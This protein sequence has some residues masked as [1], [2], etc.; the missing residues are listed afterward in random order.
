[1]HRETLQRLGTL[2]RS[3]WV[4]TLSVGTRKTLWYR[5]PR[6]LRYFLFAGWVVGWISDSVIRHGFAKWFRGVVEYAVAFP[7]CCGVF[8]ASCR[9]PVTKIITSLPLCFPGFQRAREPEKICGTENPES[10]ATF[11]LQD[12]LCQTSCR[13]R[14]TKIITSLPLRFSDFQRAREPE[15]LCGTENPES[16]VRSGVKKRGQVFEFWLYK[17]STMVT[18]V[19]YK[20]LWSWSF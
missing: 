12:P 3:I 7:P 10:C 5:K 2:E 16:W 13:L 19:Q 6:V 4:T 11:C 15:N 20:T 1:M 18:Y 9:L 8:Q 14:V 17:R